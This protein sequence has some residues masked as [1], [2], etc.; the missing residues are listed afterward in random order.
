MS[1]A[2]KLETENGYKTYYS[3]D[4]SKVATLAKRNKILII[5]TLIL[6]FLAII[7]SIMIPLFVQHF[8]SEDKENMLILLRDIK[9]FL[10]ENSQESKKIEH[11]NN[12][13]N[14]LCTKKERLCASDV[15]MLE[16]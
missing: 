2:D 7:V 15:G 1:S 8:Q 9:T 11:D 10:K 4:N 16:C 14:C 3:I 6:S 13:F 5:I 12:A